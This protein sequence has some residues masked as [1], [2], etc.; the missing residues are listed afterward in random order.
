MTTDILVDA[1]EEYVIKNNV[2]GATFIVGLYDDSTDG[3]TDASVV[4]DVTTEPTNTNYARQSVTVS[5][6]DIAG[7]WGVQNDAL[8][9]LDFSDVAPG[10]P[11]AQSVDAGFV[12]VNFQSE[13]LGQASAND[14]LIGNFALEQTRNTDELDV[15][16]I[17][18][19]DLDLTIN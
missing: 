14:N 16:E 10:D 5:A 4:G 15:I 19:G 9:E 3:L 17:G 2:D 18:A 8:V 12:L 7:D 1:G 6:A 11:E 13:E